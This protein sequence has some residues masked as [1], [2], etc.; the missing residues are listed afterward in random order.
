[1]EGLQ[2]MRTFR[3]LGIAASG[4]LVALASTTGCGSDFVSFGGFG[5]GGSG[6]G[7]NASSGNGGNASSGNGGNASS[8][9]GGSASSGNGGNASSGNGGSA[10]SGNGG[11]ASSSSGSST[12]ASSSSVSSTDASSTSGGAIDYMLPCG[13]KTCPLVCCGALLQS[14]SD[15]V[16][17]CLATFAAAA[18]S[19]NDTD[20]CEPGGV[21]CVQ[22][23]QAGVI[24][25]W[26]STCAPTCD[27]MGL[28]KLC[29][30]P[31]EC[32]PG[33]SCVPLQILGVPGGYTYCKPP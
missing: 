7:G 28:Y 14:C 29:G 3:V 12:D 4:A 15:S 19:C 5:T 22:Q 21:C 11:S 26:A 30:T 24:K 8:G 31:A 27:G 2:A 32:A 23:H 9:N 13:Q 20:D 25:K 1:M 10:S 33:F 17:A 18:M 16:D 6:N